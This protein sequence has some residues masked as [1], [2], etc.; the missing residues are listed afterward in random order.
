MEPSIPVEAKDPRDADLV[1]DYLL[2]HRE[3]IRLW[4]P[5]SPEVRSLRL[6]PRVAKR[7][8]L[9]WVQV[10]RAGYPNRFVADRKRVCNNAFSVEET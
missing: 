9:P 5:E 1:L 7:S 2:K 10:V 6:L 3:R 8:E 4:E